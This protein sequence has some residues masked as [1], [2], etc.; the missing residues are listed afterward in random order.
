MGKKSGQLWTK[1]DLNQ[2]KNLAKQNVDTDDIAKKLER[3]KD[4]IYKK[5]SK[6]DISLMPKDKK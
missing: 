3:T 6:E 4:A 5:A 1:D 2:L